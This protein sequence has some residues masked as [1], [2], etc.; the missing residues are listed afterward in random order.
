MIQKPLDQITEAVLKSLIENEVVERK[1]LDY[2]RDL[3]G[4]NDEQ[5]RKFLSDVS[6]FTNTVTVGSRPYGENSGL[7]GRINNSRRTSQRANG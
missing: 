3:P 5:R 6:S 1:N 2:K 4:R 7:C